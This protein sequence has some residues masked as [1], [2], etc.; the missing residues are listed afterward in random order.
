MNKF[1]KFTSILAIVAV[2]F[3]AC[4]KTDAP[5]D[6]TAD[7]TETAVVTEEAG[8]VDSALLANLPA[9]C[10]KVND[11]SVKTT[12]FEEKKLDVKSAILTHA[13][14]ATEGR[15]L[16][17]NYTIDPK[18]SYDNITGENIFIGIDLQQKEGS[19]L[20]IGTFTR[21]AD[22]QKQAVPDLRTSE[23]LIGFIG[24][25]G[26]VD[27]IYQDDKVACGTVDIDDGYASIK[28]SFVAEVTNE[29]WSW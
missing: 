9:E 23:S 1:L 27:L 5:A 28:G 13:P 17:G 7:S 20:T 11:I 18:K 15:L 4:S 25:K 10:S 21:T 29:A 12:S 3:S 14:Q 2:S 24:D 26:K 16:I 8:P 22:A 6:T 19:P